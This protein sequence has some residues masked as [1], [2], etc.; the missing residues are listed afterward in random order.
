[1]PVDPITPISETSQASA[2]KALEQFLAEK[3]IIA[4]KLADKTA[5]LKVAKDALEAKD[6][7]KI[8]DEKLQKAKSV[9]ADQAEQYQVKKEADKHAEAAKILKTDQDNA[10]ATIEQNTVALESFLA[11]KTSTEEVNRRSDNAAASERAQTNILNSKSETEQAVEAY[12][13]N[14]ATQYTEQQ[15]TNATEASRLAGAATLTISQ[16]ISPTPHINVMD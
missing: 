15:A 16:D 6:L 3:K 14:M 5:K 9:K 10:N 11:A 13:D 12:H 4:D 2:N 8:V 7:N 1:M